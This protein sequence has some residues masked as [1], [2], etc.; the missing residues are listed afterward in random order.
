LHT[1]SLFLMRVLA[2]G[3]TWIVAVLPV[4]LPGVW[5][6]RSIRSGGLPPGKSAN[7]WWPLAWV[8]GLLYLDLACV[9]APKAGPFSRLDWNWQGKLLE[10]AWACLFLLMVRGEARR[11]GL[12][13]RPEG[14]SALPILAAGFAA[15]ALPMLFWFQGMRLPADRETLLFELTI[16]GISEELVFRGI[17]QSL[18]NQVFPRRWHF[19]GAAFGWGAVLTAVLFSVAHGFLFDP[20]LHFQFSFFS[21]VMT[22]IPAALLG[23]LRERTGTIWPGIIVHNLVD[24]LPLLATLFLGSR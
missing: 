8:A 21:I 18:L 15:C 7:R 20:R 19:A 4:A 11:Y 6:S 14:K 1:A 2:T 12:R 23:W 3:T 9:L 22:F 5:S 16:P 10:C 17:F 24:G 13:L